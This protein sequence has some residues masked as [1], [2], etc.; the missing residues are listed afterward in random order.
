MVDGKTT[1]YQSSGLPPPELG[2]WAK[3]WE[4]NQEGWDLSGS[5]RKPKE[6]LDATPWCTFPDTIEVETKRLDSW[7]HEQED[8][9]TI[10]FIW[11]DVQ[12]AEADMISGGQEALA[13]T[14]Y[15]YTEYSNREIYEGQSDLRELLAMLPDYEIIYRYPHD[16]LLRNCK[17]HQ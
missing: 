15:L 12:G 17:R 5:I 1:F 11:A 6:H 13:R 14:R 4:D 9:D 7:L 2:N 3:R 8:I 10:D 16:V